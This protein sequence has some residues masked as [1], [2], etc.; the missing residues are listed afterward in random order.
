[1]CPMTRDER[2]LLE[3]RQRVLERTSTL[4]A[5]LKDNLRR[6]H[7]RSC[8]GRRYRIPYPEQRVIAGKLRFFLAGRTPAW[9]LGNIFD[10]YYPLTADY[11]LPGVEVI[12]DPSSIPARD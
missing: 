7:T 1:M 6:K 3:S 9:K 10:P 12:D 11:A 4:H 2:K 8:D 5:K